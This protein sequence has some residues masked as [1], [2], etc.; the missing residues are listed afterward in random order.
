VAP[1]SASGDSEQKV[2]LKQRPS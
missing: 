2:R 1:S